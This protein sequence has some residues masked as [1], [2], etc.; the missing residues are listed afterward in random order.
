MKPVIVLSALLLAGISAVAP[1]PARAAAAAAPAT[2]ATPAHGKRVIGY[3]A[4]WSAER[5]P[6]TK[7]RG[8]LLTHVN[9]AFA[10]IDKDNQCQPRDPKHAERGFAQLRELKK[11]H[12]HL[13]TL[14]SVGGWTDSG[15]FYEMAKTP[16]TRA[17]FATSAAA[18]AKRHGFDGV[19]IDWEYPG[20]GGHD[21]G[22]GGPE[23][24]PNFTAL[25]A[26]LRKQLDAQGMADNRKYLLT[27]AAPAGGAHKRIELDR[28]YP[29][30][31]FINIMTYDFAGS[32]SERTAFNA[33]L[34]PWGEHDA[35]KYA[36]DSAVQAY[37]KAGVPPEKIVLGVPFYGRAFGGVESRDSN[38]LNQRFDPKAKTTSPD[39][40]GWRGLSK[41]LDKIGTRF[42]HD[43]AKVPWLFNE[44]T[45]LFVTYDDPQS[46]RGKAEYVRDQ[47][48][49]GVM[50]WELSDDDEEASLLEAINEGL[51][52]K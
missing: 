39:G 18:F 32:W 27:I 11:K 1:A 47:K 20:G 51:G 41:N 22:K 38:G 35:G 42:W 30:L 6:A 31:D 17:T 9:Y 12:P 25:M 50:I 45:G 14:I 48:L 28:V 19:D 2:S 46:L 43:R 7:I 49:G 52:G 3:Y 29:L 10:V 8:E 23:D 37:R 24:T 21:K 13:R 33:P 16:Q 26:E 44:Q 34:Y 15:G 40:W 4:G 5:F 36:G